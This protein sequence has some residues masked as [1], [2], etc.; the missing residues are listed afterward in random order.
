MS[1]SPHC[2]MMQLNVSLCEKCSGCLCSFLSRHRGQSTSQKP[3]ER[4]VKNRK[5]LTQFISRSA[6][7]A[8]AHEKEVS[9]TSSRCAGRRHS[10]TAEL[11]RNVFESLHRK[12]QQRW[13][14]W[15]MSMTIREIISSKSVGACFS[16]FAA[17]QSPGQF[18]EIE[19]VHWFFF[20]ISRETQCFSQF[21]FCPQRQA[22]KKHFSRSFGE[23]L[24]MFEAHFRFLFVGELFLSFAH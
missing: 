2:P 24:L 15:L 11:I 3:D 13:W 19:S 9:A 5:N 14:W 8:A 4:W 10:A 21:V 17:H 7:S 16:L 1:L 23:I 18:I 6:V 20:A 22:M 12:E